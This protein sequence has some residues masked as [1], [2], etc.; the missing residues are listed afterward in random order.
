MDAA[1]TR[2]PV[3]LTA[4][5]TIIGLLPMAYG[6]SF[7]FFDFSLQI[8]SESSEWWAPMAWT[9]IFGLGFATI[10]TLFVVPALTYL[11]YRLRG[12]KGD[13]SMPVIQLDSDK[14]KVGNLG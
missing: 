14:K 6:I 2:R 8:G 1:E 11:S 12:I 9:I 10:L 5:T 13:E 7:N 3:L 4:I